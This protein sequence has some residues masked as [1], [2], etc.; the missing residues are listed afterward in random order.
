MTDHDQFFYG[1]QWQKPLDPEGRIQAVSPNDSQLLGS[2]VAPGRADVDAAV[3][4]A[5]DA[6]EDPRGWSSWPTSARAAAMERLADILEVR[7]EELATLVSAQNGMP[8]SQSLAAEA[9]TGP[10][11]L[12][13]YASMIRAQDVEELRDGDGRDLIVRSEP[14]GV[15]AS[16]V[17]WNFPIG[18][19][20]MKLAPLMA[21]GCTTVLKPSPETVLDS[22]VLA[23]CVAEAELP[24]GVLNILPG[25][26][27][28]GA[29]LVEH[30]GVDKVTFTGSTRGGRQVAQRCGELLRPVSLELGGKSAG[31]VLDDADLLTHRAE[32]LGATMFNNGQ[33]CWLSTRILVPKSRASEFLD[34][35][36]DIVASQLVGSSLDHDTEIGP[37]A[38]A[39]HRDRVEG[40]LQR[41]LRQGARVTTGEAGPRDGSRV[42]SSNRRSS[43]ILTIA[44]KLP[45][46]RSSVQCC[47]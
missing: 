21:A 46:R 47:A 7:G 23:E 43:P 17:P 5:Q 22:F 14:V 3:A 8:I 1:G 30:P 29:Y 18:L 6:F 24:P 20:F 32:F 40:F 13:Y 12:R 11:L 27:E 45:G 9:T 41:G 44:P 39:G 31:I 37:M 10:S 4:A 36:T 2:C 26:R 15:V 33:T 35:V 25:D 34:A 28:L 16:I 38:T 19:A 42:G